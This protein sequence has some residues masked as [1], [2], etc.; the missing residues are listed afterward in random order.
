MKYLLIFLSIFVLINSTVINEDII[1]TF[2]ESGSGSS[3]S[4]ENGFLALRSDYK[5]SKDLF[6]SN[7]IE[8]NTAFNLDISGSSKTYPLKCRL[9]KVA[10]KDIGLICRFEG[11]LEKNETI[12]IDK[13]VNFPYKTYN[14]QLNFNIKDYELYK[15]SYKIPFLYSAEQN[16]NV[17]EN[18]NIINFEFKCESYNNEPLVIGSQN[19]FDSLTLENC[20][21]N[22]KI[23]NCEISRK[24]LDTISLTNNIYYLLYYHDNIGRGEFRYVPEINITYYNVVKEDIYLKIEKPVYTQIERDYK[25][26][27]PTNITNLPSIKTS[28]FETKISNKDINCFLIKHNEQNPLYFVCSI[29]EDK[30]FNIGN[31]EGFKQYDINCKYNFILNSGKMDVDITFF[32]ESAEPIDSRFPEILDFSKADTLK[33]YLSVNEAHGESE[34]KTRLN[35]AG[36]NLECSGSKDFKVCKVPKSH[37]NGAKSGHYFIRH[38]C[39]GNNCIINY[40][41]FGINVVLPGSQGRAFSLSIFLFGLLSL[42]LF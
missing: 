9:I 10:E 19:I 28:I 16:I 21:K 7:D 20:K 24:K 3:I 40:E 1:I 38:N 34:K 6:D 35:E 15:V 8:E 42:I 17:Q 26:I 25:L 27:F 14:V 18:Q 39:N 2:K 37:F 33:I 22:G 4:D 23:L 30:S 32:E 31:Y 13:S 12:S 41:S 11:P 29:N 5:D 36:D